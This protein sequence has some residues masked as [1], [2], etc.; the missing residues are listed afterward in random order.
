M[1]AWALREP[2]S[3][4]GSFVGSVLVRNDMDFNSGRNLLL[5]DI[6]ELRNSREFHVLIRALRRSG[7]SAPESEIAAA[8]DR[9]R[10]SDRK[11][12]RSSRAIGVR[13]ARRK[14]VL[15][16]LGLAAVSERNDEAI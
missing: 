16:P 9:A 4:M 12:D 6:E 14:D 2:F 1:K 13:T 10:P 5:D 11:A 7:R 15:H 8:K 3:D